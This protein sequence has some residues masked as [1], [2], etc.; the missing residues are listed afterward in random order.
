MLIT[1]SLLDSHSL[2]ITGNSESVYNL[3][4]LD[5]KDGPLVVE[6]PPQVLGMINDF[7]GRYVCDL[8]RAGPD[9]GQGGKYLLLPPGY[10]GEVP[11]GY[12][13]VSL[14]HL[15]QLSVL[16]RLRLGR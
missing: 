12:F 8:G 15:R 6:V 5:T 13:V 3:G 16:S 14:P 1:E 2:L 11:A 4:W 7:W 10:T 9:Q